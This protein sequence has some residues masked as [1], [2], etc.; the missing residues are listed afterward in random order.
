MTS[1]FS[2]PQVTLLFSSDGLVNQPCGGKIL[3]CCVP[4]NGMVQTS[5][6]WSTFAAQEGLLERRTRTTT[7]VAKRVDNVTFGSG[8]ERKCTGRKFFFQ[9]CWDICKICKVVKISGCWYHTMVVLY[10]LLYSDAGIFPK[11]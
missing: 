10:L 5:G 6:V 2:S 8:E 1:S 7:C 11:F 3:G 9:C 4:T